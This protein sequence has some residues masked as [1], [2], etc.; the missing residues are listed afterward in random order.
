[1]TTDP[2]I[3]KQLA[4]FRI[5]RVLGR[6]GMA[7]VYYGQDIKLQRPVAIKVIDARY[8]DNPQYA[9][10][11]ITEAR[12]VARWRHENIIQIYYADD[13][14]GL[15]YYVM[16]YIDGPDLASVLNSHAARGEKL[17]Q[18][19]VLRIG[20]AIA[21]ALDYAHKH[22]V[23][24]RDVK[25]SNIFL[26]KDGRIVLGDF[27]LA[28]D[29]NQGSSGEAFG[30]PHYISPEQARRSLDA[31]PQSDLYS[32]G[33]ILYEMLTGVVPFD[34][35][36]PTSV[37]LQHLTQPPPPPR[38]LN[39]Q[40]NAETEAVLLKAL[41]K[42]PKE[43]YPSGAALVAALEQALAKPASTRERILP[44]PPMPAAVVGGKTRPTTRKILPDAPKTVKRSRWPL[45]LLLLLAAL[46]SFIFFGNVQLRGGLPT[47]FPFLAPSATP[48]PTWTS[49][50]TATFS[51]LPSNTSTAT[52]T[53]T[54]THTVTPRP[55]ATRTASA[56]DTPTVT[57]TSTFAITATLT[58]FPLTS[59]TPTPDTLASPTT[60]PQFPNLKRM[61][62]YYDS[63]GFY[64]YNASSDNRSISP[65]AFERLDESNRFAGFLWAEFYPTLHPGRCM[66]I[67]IQKNPGSYLNPPLCKDYYLSTRSITRDNALI[68]WTEQP[69]SAQFRVL[70]QNQEVGLCDIA[71]GF[72]EVFVP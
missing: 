40:L 70:W 18:A 63:Y 72:C 16:E 50:P 31:V 38:S 58:P 60:T 2:L 23:I 15:Y 66:R 14:D 71:A 64:I 68:F 56:T 26:S 13:Q 54:P 20:K 35:I 10:R 1:M 53:P 67:E 37:A 61:W 48:T 57:T 12:A 43:R 8:R 7:Q 24:H 55:S 25:P 6:G 62:L 34:D 27:G 17:S 22:G 39:P 59:D 30:S 44:L 49:L 41:S 5:E 52:L 51:P 11:F 46:F 3:G 47:L 45:V 42:N 32:L 21:S 4:N 69:G 29:L 33:V 28:L 65:I 36:S 19:E 9:R